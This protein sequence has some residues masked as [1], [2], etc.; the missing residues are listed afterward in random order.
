MNDNMFKDK[1]LINDGLILWGFYELDGT[2]FIISMVCLDKN[3]IIWSTVI[4]L[5]FV[6]LIYFIPI[7]HVT[8]FN[9]IISDGDK[10]GRPRVLGEHISL[11]YSFVY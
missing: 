5:L 7:S 3:F 9:L 10:V 2:V 6:M 11:F 4:W 8:L 1:R